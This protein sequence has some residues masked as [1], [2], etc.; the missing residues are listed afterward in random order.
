[1]TFR[2]FIGSLRKFSSVRAIPSSSLTFALKPST[3]SAFPGSP[4]KRLTS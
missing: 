3:F 4:V 2:T 1:M